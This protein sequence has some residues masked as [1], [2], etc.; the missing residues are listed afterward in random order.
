MT[1][2]AVR[3]P[4]ERLKKLPQPPPNSRESR[5]SQANLRRSWRH[6]HLRHGYRKSRGALLRRS[7][8]STA[9][10]IG[11]FSSAWRTNSRNVAPERRGSALASARRAKAN[12]V[13]YSLRKRV[14][15]L[16]EFIASER[17][18]AAVAIVGA[19]RRMTHEE[20]AQPII[21]AGFEH[22]FFERMPERIDDVLLGREQARGFETPSSAR[23][24][25][26]RSCP[27]NAEI[28]MERASSLRAT[29]RQAGCPGWMRRS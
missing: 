29:R 24:K 28:R 14:R 17:H 7:W 23:L 13:D 15:D 9:K 26:G 6:G 12:A 8:C 20:A 10:N 21:D 27:G 4:A 1:T 25:G 18:R 5:C 3:Q 19:G 11:R 2:N 22:A 16:H